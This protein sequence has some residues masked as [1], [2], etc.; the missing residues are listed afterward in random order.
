MVYIIENNGVYGLTKGQFSATADVGSKLKSGLANDF[1]PVDTC[2]LAIEL[3]C[4]YVVR[5]FSG[6]NKQL[7]PL[8]QGALAHQGTALLDIISPCITFNNHEGSTMSYTSVR[9]HDIPLHEIGFVPHFEPITADFEPGTIKDIPLPDGS[10]LR[11][12]KLGRDYDPTNRKQAIE[13]LFES[14]AKGELLTGLIYI[15]EGKPNY[16][17][18]MHLSKTPLARLGDKELRPSKEALEELMQEMM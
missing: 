11:L 18:L 12:K 17:D 14:R 1:Q 9:E 13:S 4:A 6:D 10:H 3:G 8:I 7:V 16:N 5:S 2:A 15:Q